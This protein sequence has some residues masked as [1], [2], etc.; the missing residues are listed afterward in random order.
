MNQPK[1]AIIIISWNGKHLLEECLNSAENQDYSNFKIIFV[2]N[3]STDG[4]VEFVKEKF[5]K[6]EIIGLDK[7]T[8]FAKA[9]NV[10]M[11]KAFEDQE[12][13]YIALLNN[14]AMA[15]KSWLS[16]MV[17]VIKQDEKIGSV[18]PKILK[19]WRRDFIDSIGTEIH[20]DGGAVGRLINKKDDYHQYNKSIEIFG[21]TACSCL[22]NRKML[23][24]IIDDDYFDNSFFLYVEEI[25]LNWRARLRGWKCFTAPSA[26]VYHKHSETAVMYSSVKLY[27]LHR[28]RF[29]LIVKNFPFRFLGGGFYNIFYRYLFLIRKKAI[30]KKKGVISKTIEKV[31]LRKVVFLIA[32]GWIAFLIF[33]PGLLKKRYYIQKRKMVDNR[34][35]F[36]WFKEFGGDYKKEIFNDYLK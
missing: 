36:S 5:S 25:D 6:V 31:G 1:I 14:D 8:G 30:L 13:E 34:T 10:G 4:S 16:E 7:N 3:G 2:D 11:H 12:I 27:Y 15:E 18:A 29:F 19:Y 32:K 23:E 33:L 28:N 9:N 17:K 21:P 24:D 22:Y 26:I 35:I 20:S